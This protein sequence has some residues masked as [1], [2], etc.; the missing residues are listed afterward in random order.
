MTRRTY[1]K[2]RVG[3]EA[4]ALE[5]REKYPYKSDSELNRIACNELRKS[6][7]IVVSEA[8]QKDW[9]S[10]N[11]PTAYTPRNF[12]SHSDDEMFQNAIEHLTV[13]NLKLTKNAILDRI[14][15]ENMYMGVNAV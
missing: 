7:R 2:R 1:S 10:Q 11:V 9:E 5:L 8:L 6:K 13:H 12:K 3:I 14:I 4:R 15:Q